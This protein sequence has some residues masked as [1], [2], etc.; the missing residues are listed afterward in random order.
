MTSYTQLVAAASAKGVALATSFNDVVSLVRAV[1]WPLAVLLILLFLRPYLPGL[2]RGISSRISRV[3]WASVSV[4]FAASEVRP[5]VWNSLTYLRDPTAV[6]RWSDSG[7]M[8]FNLIK[9]GER[10]D[11][12]TIDLGTGKRWLTSRLH[13]FS[14]LLPELLGVQCL[15]FL[16]SRDG[17][18]RSF[19]G[20]A[21]PKAV[22][23]ALARRQPWLE[24]ALLAARLNLGR[25]EAAPAFDEFKTFLKTNAKRAKEIT[26]WELDAP[27]KNLV[28][29]AYQSAGDA[30]AQA[31]ENLANAYLRSPLLYR[32]ADAT[33]STEEEG[34]ITLG[35]VPNDPT[36]VRQ[37][38]ASW[39]QDGVHLERILRDSLAH[40][41]LTEATGIPLHELQQ[42][43][44]LSDDHE[45][46]AVIDNQG[47][48]KRLF[49]RR[50]IAERLGYET[51]ERNAR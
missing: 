50:E 37:E 27:L 33:S 15:V 31:A 19:V 14:T 30:D 32:E 12:A 41:S 3:S 48:F 9:S 49:N 22:R 23:V 29:S 40:S 42:Q 10:A 11:S 45:F 17:I 16:E 39:I 7:Q 25:P 24:G 43:I 6:Q 2:M 4:E 38:R 18:F 13:I 47:R 1:A 26:V 34:W 5:E 44:V 36:K 35:P 21:D 51:A 8:L 20:L 46:V 28:G